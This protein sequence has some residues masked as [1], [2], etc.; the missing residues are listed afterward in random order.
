MKT[1]LSSIFSALV[2]LDMGYSQSSY[3]INKDSVIA[4]N[5]E[6]REEM[7][8][9]FADPNKSALPL[10][11]VDEFKEAPYFDINLDYVVVA[12]FKEF[13]DGPIIKMKTSTDRIAEYRL[14]GKAYF[15]LAKDSLSLNLYKSNEE[16]GDGKEHLFLPFKDLTNKEESYTV[17]RY[18]DIESPKDGFLIIDFNKSYNPS[19]AYSNRY[20]CPRVPV[21][22]HLNVPIL[23]GAKY[24]KHEDGWNELDK[25]PEY[26]GNLGSDLRRNLKYPKKARKRKIEGIVYVKMVVNKDGSMSDFQVAKGIHE[27]CDKVALSAVR[28]LKPFKPGVK[29]GKEVRSFVVLPINFKL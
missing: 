23:A 25:M 7:N 17:G 21:E 10:F 2:L 4:D 5:L 14:Y 28:S 12:E 8:E 20:S 1:F 29:D 15:Q 13:E 3:Q 24:S 6:F 26:T 16:N 11:L 19:C 27:E 22:N 18:L 9:Y